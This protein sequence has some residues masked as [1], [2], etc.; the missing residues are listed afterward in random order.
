M[1]DWQNEQNTMQAAA[2]ATQESEAASQD[3]A[4]AAAANAAV[5]IGQ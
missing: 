4:N 1:D 5:G 2:T 3:A